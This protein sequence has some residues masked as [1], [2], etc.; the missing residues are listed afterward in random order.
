MTEHVTSLRA[1]HNRPKVNGRSLE[2]IMAELPPIFSRFPD[3]LAVYLFGSYLSGKTH[4]ESDLDLAVVP[5]CSALRHQRLEILT[6]LARHGFTH[7]DLVFLDTNDI[8]L[9]FEAVRANRLVYATAEFDRSSYFS[10]II[11]QYF[12]FE[13]YLK[14][15]REATKR[16]IL[17]G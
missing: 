4:V 8:V 12:D 17:G 14:Q 5:H 7:V 3:I 2:Q 15:Q 1:T 10:K 9:K 11:R 13:P 16:R 6:E